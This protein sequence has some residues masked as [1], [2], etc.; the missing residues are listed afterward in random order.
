MCAGMV[1]CA[2]NG[3]P[4][5]NAKPRTSQA[6]AERGGRRDAEVAGFASMSPDEARNRP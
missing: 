4:L 1:I 2:H 6:K 5:P 3:L